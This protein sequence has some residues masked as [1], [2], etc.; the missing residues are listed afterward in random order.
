[1][2][3]GADRSS[4]WRPAMIAAAA[5][6]A[7][8]GTSFWRSFS[9]LADLAQQYGVP[10]S[11]AWTLPITVDGLVIAATVAAVARRSARWYAWLLLIIGTVVSVVGNGIHAWLLT[12]SSIGVG[13]AVLPPLITL[14]SVHL[15]VL[16][17]RQE[18]RTD[19]TLPDSGGGSPSSRRSNFP[20]PDA[21]ETTPPRLHVAEPAATEPA[22]EP[23]PA[24]TAATARAT[25]ASPAATP[26]PDATPAATVA[27]AATARATAPRPAAT[28]DATPATAATAP[29]ATPPASRATAPVAVVATPATP[30]AR[31]VAARAPE[32]AADD[33]E[34]MRHRAIALVERDGVSIRAAADELGISKDRVHRWVRSHRAAAPARRIRPA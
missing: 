9:A 23:A 8:A 17:A 5:A 14:A 1:M 34:R 4:L 32:P 19:A 27:T 18:H 29:A 30:L 11:Q 13:I 10:A 22:T 7:V 21:G 28:P 16:L 6:I 24:A 25:P 3:A 33:E 26:E 20:E 31:P 2:T 15:A 12:T